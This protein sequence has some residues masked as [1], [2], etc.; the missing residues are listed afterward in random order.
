MLILIVSHVTATS[1][2]L[3]RGFVTSQTPNVS[4]KPMFNKDHDVTFVKRDILI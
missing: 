1:G 2:V 3:Q 4:V